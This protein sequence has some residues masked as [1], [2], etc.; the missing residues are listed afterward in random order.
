METLNSLDLFQCLEHA[1]T[2]TKYWHQQT[3][4][5]SE[6]MA[7]GAFYGALDPLADSLLETYMGLHTRTDEEYSFKFKSY[8]EGI[9]LKYMDFFHQKLK[10][11]QAEIQETC[12]KNIIDEIMALVGQTKYLLTLS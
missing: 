5:Y 8:S 4:K 7:L 9:A 6:H 3:K 12:L 10:K 2:Q 11:F 1:Y